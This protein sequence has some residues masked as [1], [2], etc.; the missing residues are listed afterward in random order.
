VA[1]RFLPLQADA[2]PMNPGCEKLVVPLE[3]HQIC[4]APMP[5][6]A[7]FVLSAAPPPSSAVH[8]ARLVGIV[9]FIELIGSTFNARLVNPSRLRR[10]FREMRR[11]LSRTP[12][13]RLTYPRDMDVLPKVR[14]AILADLDS[15]QAEKS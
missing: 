1:R 4:T 11:L 6:H 8:L 5:L 2:T 14:E 12:I 7:F 13:K 3:P 9:P 10:Q 15:A